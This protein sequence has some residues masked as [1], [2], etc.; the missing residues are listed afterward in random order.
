MVR[1]EIN[2][3]EMGKIIPETMSKEKIMKAYDSNTGMTT[4]EAC[5]LIPLSLMIIL[6]LIWSGFYKYDLCVISE[7]AAAA[8]MNGALEIG[9]S[10][11]EISTFVDGKVYELLNEKLICVRDI[12]WDISVSATKVSVIIRGKFM[13]PSQIFLT[14]LYERDVWDFEIEK[15]ELRINPSMLLRMSEMMHTLNYG[16]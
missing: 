10:N 12:N 16:E 2:M 7:A 5:I 1:G 4:I 11:E 13:I 6:L 9:M 3:K 8:S 15:S 14:K